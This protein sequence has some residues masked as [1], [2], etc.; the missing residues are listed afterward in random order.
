MIL[1]R[2]LVEEQ[3]W[4]QVHRSQVLYPVW[5]QIREQIWNQIQRQIK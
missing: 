3:L 5:N 1:V 2:K 4:N